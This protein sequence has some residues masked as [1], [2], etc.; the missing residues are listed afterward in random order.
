M[1]MASPRILTFPADS[2]PVSAGR[3]VG[4]DAD[5]R[6]LVTL[7]GEH[8]RR[9]ARSLLQL[10]VRPSDFAALPD[11]AITFENGDP[12]LPLIVGW[13]HEQ[14]V[15]QH[16]VEETAAAV[17]GVPEAFVDGERVVFRA[18]QEIVL[19]CGAS[20]IVLTRDG[21]VVI[22]GAHVVSRSSGV[23]KIKG[24]TVSIN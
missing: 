23:N 17:R 6:P 16:P 19:E 14:L 20:S 7:S 11:V 5:G 21:H 13:I 4:I 9:V 2:V 8:E 12:H 1:G 24:A 3:L 18:E 15:S 22:K 10:T